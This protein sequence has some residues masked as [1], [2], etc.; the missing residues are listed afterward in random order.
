MNVK[1]S[2]AAS[3]DSVRGKEKQDKSVKKIF[4]YKPIMGN[5]LKYT[6]KEYADCSLDEIMNC[7]EGDTI[8]AGTA[9]V[10]EDMAKTIRGEKTECNT[11]DEPPATFDILFRSVNPK[12]EGK[13]LVN[14]HID[15]E[16][17]KKY[18]PGYFIVKRGVYYGGRKLSA[19]LDKIGVNGKGYDLLEKVYSIWICLDNI[20]KKLQNTIS[21][22]KMQN[23]KN[24][25]L[26]PGSQI[27]IDAADLIEV[28]IVRLGD[29]SITE[30]GIMDM[31][32]GIFSGN[33]K[34]VLDYIPD[35]DPVIE[36]EVSDMLSMVSFAEEKGEKK[37]MNILTKLFQLLRRDGREKD[38]SDAID[39]PERQNELLKEYEEELKL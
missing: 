9:L 31:L 21:Y 30:K 7:I 26:P 23:Y 6:I 25:G 1:D 11:T 16:L 20:P 27:D 33:S 13:I 39:N 15:F 28:I 19:Q 5:I 18:N 12:V 17:Q 35:A 38:I 36:K 14:L 8:Q 2:I 37:G 22:Y 3:M 4:S 29:D 10:E 24:E 32:Y 34:K